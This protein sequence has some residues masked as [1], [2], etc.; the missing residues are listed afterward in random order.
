LIKFV[1][2]LLRKIPNKPRIGTWFSGGGA[3]IA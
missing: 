3:C 1:T 2:Q